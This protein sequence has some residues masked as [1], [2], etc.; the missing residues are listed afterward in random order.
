MTE[1]DKILRLV[2]EGVLSAEEADRILA[3]LGDERPPR[4]P[5]GQPSRT[6]GQSL[7]GEP[8]SGGVARHLRIEITDRGRKVVNLRVP[9]NVASFAAG[10]V[11]GLPDED[12]ERVRQTIRAGVRGPIVDI[13]SEDGE[14]VLIVSE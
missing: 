14:R 12:A 5:S 7:E 9:I 13:T 11:P 1:V 6:S 2:E 3:A 8:A 4:T 10:I